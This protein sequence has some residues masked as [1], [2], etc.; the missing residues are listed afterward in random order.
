M[1][2]SV[3][4]SARTS[5]PSS[6]PASILDTVLA[7][8]RS[9]DARFSSASSMARRARMAPCSIWFAKIL[10]FSA[11]NSSIV[12]RA[13]RISSMAA[14]TMNAASTAPMTAR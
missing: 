12:S 6:I 8:V 7:T 3:T 14:A 13:L 2:F 9:L 10:P 11:I 5:C 4:S 1:R